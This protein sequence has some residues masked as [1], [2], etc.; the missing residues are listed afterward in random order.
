MF[1]LIVIAYTI[2]HPFIVYMSYSTADEKLYSSIILFYN[3]FVHLTQIVI[4][5]KLRADLKRYHNLEYKLNS[6]SLNSISLVVLIDILIFN[7]RI[8]MKLGWLGKD[9][10]INTSIDALC[11]ATEHHEEITAFFEKVFDNIILNF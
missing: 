10:K 2:G 11:T 6:K 7:Y 3:I 9:L 8:M 1:G 5:C 4:F